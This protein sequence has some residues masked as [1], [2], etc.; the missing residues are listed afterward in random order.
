MASRSTPKRVGDLVGDRGQRPERHRLVG[1]VFERFDRTTGV[2][3]R[4]LLL[5]RRRRPG[6]RAR[7]AQEPD[8]GAVLGLGE[9]LGQLGQDRAGERLVADLEDPVGARRPGRFGTGGSRGG[10]A[11]RPDRPAPAPPSR[12]IRPRPAGSSPPR[13]RRPGGWSGRR[14]RRCGRTEATPDPA[15]GPDGARPAPTRRPR[16]RRRRRGRARPRASR[17]ARAGPRTGGP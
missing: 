13:R 4:L 10:P 6:R 3:G 12:P 11:D 16:H 9:R 17:P 8:D 2:T 1:L 5:A 14:S 7:P 15:R